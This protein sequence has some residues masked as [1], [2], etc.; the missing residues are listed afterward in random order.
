MPGGISLHDFLSYGSRA[1]FGSARLLS[2]SLVYRDMIGLCKMLFL[3]SFCLGCVT[4]AS[5]AKAEEAAYA[6]GAQVCYRIPHI[7]RDHLRFAVL[8]FSYVSFLRWLK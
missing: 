7:P 5:E 2:R 4:L 3:S 8:L 6:I 1:V